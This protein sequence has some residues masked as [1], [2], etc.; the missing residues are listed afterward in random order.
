MTGARVRAVQE[1]RRSGAAGPHDAA[2][3]RARELADALA[4][5]PCVCGTGFS[6][7][8]REHDRE[9]SA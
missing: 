5:E 2:R 1:R 3:P 8:A 7:L 9:V 6:C 4:D